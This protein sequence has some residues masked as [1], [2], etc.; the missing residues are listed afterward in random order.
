MA[1]EAEEEEGKKYRI[2]LLIGVDDIYL[3]VAVD[4]RLLAKTLD[5]FEDCT[6]LISITQKFGSSLHHGQSDDVML[7]YWLYESVLELGAIVIVIAD[8]QW[9]LLD[10]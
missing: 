2:V 4:R 1:T 8:Y 7:T 10:E 6:E 3:G 5:L 9:I